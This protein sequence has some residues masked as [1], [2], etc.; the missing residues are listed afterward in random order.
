[1]SAVLLETL[2]PTCYISLFLSPLPSP[3]THPPPKKKS[4][5]NKEPT[6][7][8]T[9]LLVYFEVVVPTISEVLRLNEPRNLVSLLCWY[10]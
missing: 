7:L 2:I 3:P 5:N 1:M 6:N 9:R 8:V 10:Y 4:T